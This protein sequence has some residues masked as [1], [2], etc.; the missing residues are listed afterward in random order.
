M[1]ETEIPLSARILAVADVYD[2]LTSIRSYK[3]AFTH[4]EAIEI[5]RR[6]VGTAFDPVVF[7][8]FEEVVRNEGAQLVTPESDSVRAPATTRSDRSRPPMLD[9]SS[10]DVLTGLPLRPSLERIA[11]QALADRATTNGHVS[12]LVVDVGADAIERLMQDRAGPNALLR[13][14]ARQLRNATR[15]TDFVARSNEH[16]FMALLAGSAAIDARSVMARVQ[17][18]L[19]R[20]LRRR[21][22]DL[23]SIRIAVVTAPDHGNTAR[24]AA[25]GGGSRDPGSAKDAARNSRP[26]ELKALPSDRSHCRSLSA[27]MTAHVVQLSRSRG[28]VPKL[29]VDEA[30]RHRE[31]SRR[32]TASATGDSTAGPI[33]RSVSIPTTSSSGLR[34]RA[35]RSCGDRP[36]KT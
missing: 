9:L 33:A 15:G 36:V 24:R 1:K 23:E 12:L 19:A 30:A 27:V 31:W 29:A 14:V 17:N 22:V 7:A 2:A 32:A 20:V 4:E 6:D 8:R 21:K 18:A 13:G 34:S 35:I 28:G 25:R 11:A 10:A 26:D 3:A 5:M 16:Q